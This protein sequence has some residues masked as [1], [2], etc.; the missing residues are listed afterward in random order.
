MHTPV[1]RTSEPLPE[2]GEPRPARCEVCGHRH[3]CYVAERP[4]PGGHG[5]PSWSPYHVCLGCLMRAAD[6]AA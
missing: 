6:P 3:A 2:R 4:E 1:T 5:G